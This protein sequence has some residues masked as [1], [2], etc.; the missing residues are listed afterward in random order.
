M[1]ET[2][3][4]VA[5][6]VIQGLSSYTYQPMQHNKT[7]TPQISWKSRAEICEIPRSRVL[8]FHQ[9]HGWMIEKNS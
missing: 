1:I 9:A 8:F 2:H 5:V 7:T 6:H 4:S 3:E